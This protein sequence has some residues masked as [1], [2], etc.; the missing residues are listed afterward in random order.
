[1]GIALYFSLRHE[2]PLWLVWLP[3][4]FMGLMVKASTFH[5]LSFLRVFWWCCFWLTLGVAI[6]AT[7]VFLLHT[8]LLEVA[9]AHVLLTATVDFIEQVPTQPHKKRLTFSRV[10]ASSVPGFSQS[11]LPPLGRV[12]LALSK[13]LWEERAKKG[14]T[15]KVGDNVTFFADLLPFPGPATLGGYH[16][17]RNAYFQGISATGKITD[18]LSVTSSVN[19]SPLQRIHLCQV[20]LSQMISQKFAHA[21]QIGAIVASL[22]TGDRSALSP[23]TR[24]F[25]I[26]SGLA[27]IL[28]I[29]GL[30]LSLIAGFVFL[31]MR[32]GLCLILPVTFPL[33]KWAA[34][35]VVIIVFIYL[36]LSGFAIP[37]CRA[38][39]MIFLS[40]MAIWLDRRPLSMRLVAIAALLILL[41]QP[42]ALLSASFQLSFSAVIALVA[43]FESPKERSPSYFSEYKLYKLKEFTKNI[44]LTTL[45]A[46]LATTPFTIFLFHRFTLQAIL[47]NLLAIP[48]VGF[49]IMPLCFL[50]TLSALV[51]DFTTPWFFLGKGVAVLLKI[52]QFVAQL[53]GSDFFLSGTS[54]FYLSCVVLGGLWLCL[55]QKTW[56]FWGLPVVVVGFLSIFFYPSPT[57]LVAEDGTALAFFKKSEKKLFVFHALGSKFSQGHFARGH[58]YGDMWSKDLGAVETLFFPTAPYF[59]KER[60]VL[61]NHL[62]NLIPS[63]ETLLRKGHHYIWFQDGKTWCET[64]RDY[65]GKRPWGSKR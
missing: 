9:Q 30:H 20:A 48:L 23:E 21:P 64:S 34:G 14:Q 62:K 17:R 13:A 10:Y 32:R 43:A 63:K 12:R 42:E 37:G 26:N 59:G 11:P 56:R 60:K 22:I 41:C 6:P 4:L 58:F 28:A 40:M 2:P 18:V 65:E 39:L 52:A 35:G 55:W 24:Q 44:L 61:P 16:F 46:T 50:C 45:V 57:V 38:F 49:Y 8:P 36:A 54:S 1:M 25:F 47:G 5:F 7:R 53:P 51:G 3:P 19:L 33:K 29:S 27:H 15:L 31:C